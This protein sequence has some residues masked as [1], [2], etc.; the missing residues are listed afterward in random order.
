MASFN[1]GVTEV[2]LWIDSKQANGTVVEGA[3]V[4]YHASGDFDIVTAT[5]TF[6][7]QPMGVARHAC[8]S[9]DRLSILRAGRA[10]VAANP[11]GTITQGAQAMVIS[12][13]TGQVAV[14]AIATSG[15]GIWSIGQF[16]TTQTANTSGQMVGVALN[17]YKPLL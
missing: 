7:D 1:A 8:A 17:I 10:V 9:G 4:R 13:S 14:L 16:E 12:G 11:G 5:T 3:V 6:A 2:P 15:L